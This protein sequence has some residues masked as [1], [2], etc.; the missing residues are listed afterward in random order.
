M[1]SCALLICQ[2]SRRISACY[3]V[4]KCLKDSEKLKVCFK[5]KFGNIETE[6]SLGFILADIAVKLARTIVERFS[7]VAGNSQLTDTCLTS[8]P[9][10]SSKH[11]LKTLKNASPSL[12]KS[13]KCV[14]IH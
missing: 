10:K 9:I 12:R 3:V 11:T 5:V 2:T 13:Q 6:G 14:P 8:T 4:H 1:I 7:T